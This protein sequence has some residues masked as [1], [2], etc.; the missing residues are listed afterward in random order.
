[1][2]SKGRAVR[3][4]LAA[5]VWRCAAAA[6]SLGLIGCAGGGG[7]EP[8]PTVPPPGENIVIPITVYN[9]W[10]PSTSVT[11][12]FVSLGGT[13]ILGS[14]NGGRER[15]FQVDSP[16]MTGQFRLSASGTRLD[17]DIVSQAFSLFPNSAVR[18]T[19]V[20]NQLVV[21]ERMPPP[22]EPKNQ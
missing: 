16:P 12:R 10:T 19:L 9:N 11:V 22:M 5:T 13:R 17:A 6:A 15:T 3:D 4:S 18:W 14:V 7:D 8:D 20:G 21:G 2:T 1:M